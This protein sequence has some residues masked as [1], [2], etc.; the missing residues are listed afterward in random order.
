MM[1]RS[2]RSKQRKATGSALRKKVIAV[3]TVYITSEDPNYNYSAAYKHGEKLV[4]V[5]APGQVHLSPQVALYH[6]LKVLRDFQPDDFLALAG[7]PIKIA[8]CS[9]VAQEKVAKVKFLRWDR[10][11][12]EYIPIEVD[13]D[14]RRAMLEGAA[15]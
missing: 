6:A 8:V 3:P 10:Q 1:A 12:R 2:L 9:V 15:R 7:D 14:D 4:G 5:F 13:F 11:T